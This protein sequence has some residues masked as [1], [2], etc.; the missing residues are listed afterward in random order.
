MTVVLNDRSDF[1][2]DHL[3]RVALEGEGVRFGKRALAVMAASHEAFQTYVAAEPGHFIYG[4]TSGHGPAAARRFSLDE[5]RARRRRGVP[6][7]GLSFGDGSLPEC[8]VRA[9]VFAVL[10]MYVEGH[11]AAEPER[12][13]T[14]AALLDGRMPKIPDQGLTAPG[15]MMPFFYLFRAL[16]RHHGEGLQVS[17]GNGAAATAGMTGVQAIFARR[18]L[19][20][21]ERL[22]ALSIE[23]F[24][25]PL[26]AYDPALK[27]LWGDRYESQA[28]DALRRSL[29]GA[30]TAGRRP[31]QAPVSYR[32]LPRVLGQARRSVTDLEAA[33]AA[34]LRG[35]LPNPAFLPPSRRHP[36]GR[37]LSSG[38]FHN[39]LGPQA[40]DAVAACWVDLAGLAHRHIVKLHKGDVSLLP[41]RLLPPGTDYLTGH[42]TTYLEF[43]PNGHIEEMRLLAQPSLLSPG[44]PGASTQDDVCAP[45]FMA[46]RNE[47]RVAR[48]LDRVLAILAA[49][50][51]Q[52]LH[53]TGRDAPPALRELLGDVRRLFPPVRSRRL[54][55]R[56][57]ARLATAITRAVEE[58]GDRLA[59]PPSPRAA[60]AGGR[61]RRARA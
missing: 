11:C 13:A 58:G 19:D 33:A 46:C 49:T 4:L 6:F 22:F 50:A 61:A 18:R 38:A 55:G 60:R 24:N 28:L 57:G 40:L 53:V 47:L 12:A 2:L 43:V 36:L 35:L 52:A 3:R 51:S 48:L 8:M 25:A 26:E 54:L 31:Y 17:A 23:A 7:L 16:P 10:A 44:A 34:T 1:S 27:A 59:P 30:A 56:D 20:L 9:T 21:A 42:S 15:E 29:E 32:I 45:G 14:Y 5:A 37:T 41:D 39:A